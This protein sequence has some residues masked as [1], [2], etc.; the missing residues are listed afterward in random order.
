MKSSI[1]LGIKFYKLFTSL[2][3]IHNISF[4]ML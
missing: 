4:I 3:H 2:I 1:D